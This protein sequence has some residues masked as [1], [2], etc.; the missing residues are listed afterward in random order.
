VT[1]ARP[2]L[3]VQRRP[4]SEST[5]GRFSGGSQLGDPLSD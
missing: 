1:S 3:V 2:A 4:S 5:M